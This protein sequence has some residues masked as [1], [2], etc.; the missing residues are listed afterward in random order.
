MSARNR[1][2]L[3]LVPASLLV[4]GGFAAVFIERD[5]VLSDVSLDL[6]RRVPGAVPRRPRRAA[7]HAA[8][9][10]PVPVP[11]VRGPRLLRAGDDLPDRRDARPRAGAVVRARADPVRGDDHP[12]ARLPRPRA[13]PLHDR[14]GRDPAPAAPA[15]ARDR[16]ERQRRLPRR[17]ARPAVL[18]AR[19][20]R[21][22]RDHHLPG[23]LPARHAPAAGLG[24][25]AGRRRLAAAAQAPRPAAAHLGRGDG[26]ALLHP[27]HRLVADV[28][29]R[30]PRRRLRR[31]EP[32]AVRD[33]R[34]RAVRRRVVGALPGAP[35]DPE[36]RRRLA[37]PVRLV[38]LR[39]GRGQLPARPVPLRPGR[40]RASS[41][42]ASARRCSPSA[43]AT[44]RCS[45]C[46]P[47]R[48]T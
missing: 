13:L 15:R 12:A 6:R 41:G 5:D 38:A 42:R 28:L 27:G 35:H 11:V 16:P 46:P 9:R 37:A 40:R 20:V 3:A 25:A 32:A 10:R 8:Q 17:E 23:Q 45:S 33:R 24:R 34:A 4:T 21:Q 36:P 43:P 39:P 7:L 31:H 44:T 30:L 1:E 2:L 29:R 14:G 48:P 22:D 26:D 47:R 18:P 19:R